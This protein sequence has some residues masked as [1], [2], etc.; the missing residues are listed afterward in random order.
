MKNKPQNEYL[1]HAPKKEMMTIETDGRGPNLKNYPGD[2]VNEHENQETAN[3]I[4]AAG[5]IGQQME[6]N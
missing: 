6:N 3:A 2:S 1:T 4:I 5:E